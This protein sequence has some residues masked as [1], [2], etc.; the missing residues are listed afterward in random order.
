MYVKFIYQWQNVLRKIASCRR[1]LPIASLREYIISQ[2]SVNSHS[3]YKS[4]AAKSCSEK[5]VVQKLKNN[6]KFVKSTQRLSK[7]F[8]WKSLFSVNLQTSR[9]QLFQK[10]DSFKGIFQKISLDVNKTFFSDQ[11]SMVVSDKFS[12]PCGK[13]QKQKPVLSEAFVNYLQNDQDAKYPTTNELK[14]AT[15]QLSIHIENTLT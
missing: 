11:L 5:Q 6:Q 13:S 4:E 8:L 15:I 14:D 2:I 12:C 3:M 1:I 7:N 9:M 10:I